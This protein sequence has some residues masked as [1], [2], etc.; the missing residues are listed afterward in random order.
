MSIPTHPRF[1]F[2]GPGDTIAEGDTS[3]IYDFL[4]PELA[5]VAFE[6]LKKEVKWNKMMHRGTCLCRRVI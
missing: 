1:K 3:V 6:N 4:P 5:D 2:L